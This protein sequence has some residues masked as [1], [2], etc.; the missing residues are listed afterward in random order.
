MTT[1]IAALAVALFLSTAMLMGE[2][3]PPAMPPEIQTSVDRG[4]DWLARTQSRE[5]GWGRP[6]EHDVAYTALGGMAFL[7]HG[8]PPG[9]GRFGDSLSR[10]VEYLLARSDPVTGLIS[11]SGESH[12]IHC[13]GYATLFLA[14][15][16]GMETTPEQRRRLKTVLD[17]AVHLSCA[18]QTA[19]GGWGYR[20]GDSDDE[21]STTVT[22]IEGLR[23]C[24][25]AGITVSVL[26]IERALGYLQKSQN[27]DGSVRYKLRQ[28]GAGTPALTAAG[29]MCFY[30][31]GDYDKP[32]TRSA[33]SF[34][35]ACL[36]NGTLE[37]GYVPAYSLLYAAQAF[38]LAGDA[39]WAS[40]WGRHG[41]RLVKA[42]AP[43]GSWSGEPH[44]VYGTAAT[45]IILQIP[46][47]YLPFLQR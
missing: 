35:D 21:G 41:N 8:D 17:R 25:N 7:A 5:G 47:G 37:Q 28:A 43:D 30:S 18:S 15:L 20:P 11:S 16:Y 29:L 34:L 39:S 27:P 46:C 14:E 4:L 36:K 38:W 19:A 13:H 31:L 45:C 23:A 3:V 44:P 6:G 26:T 2:E 12:S 40:F 1:P 9:R 42:Q 33:L 24:R 32:H 10:A 22:Q